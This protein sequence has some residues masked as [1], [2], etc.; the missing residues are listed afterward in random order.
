MFPA[1]TAQVILRVQG[2]A[3]RAVMLSSSTARWLAI[4]QVFVPARLQA[5]VMPMFAQ[6]L[7]LRA[8]QSDAQVGSSAGTLAGKG[9]SS[10]LPLALLP[11]W[12][13][14]GNVLDTLRGGGS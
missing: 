4:G 11:A 7:A 13:C 3:E 1:L 6:R 9:R 14:A 10:F 5:S 12:I 2:D 8:S